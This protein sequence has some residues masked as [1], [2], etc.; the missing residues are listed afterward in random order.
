VQ[1]DAGSLLTAWGNF[2]V[3]TGTAAATLI[4]LMFVVITLVAGIRRRPSGGTDVFSTP[5]VVHFCGALFVAAT[6][7]AP[8]R[9]LIPVASL[10]GVAGLAG[11]AYVIIVLLRTRRLTFYK[12]VLEDWLWHMIFPFIA[13]TTIMVA[14]LLLPNNPVLALFCVG[15]V[16]V[17]LLFIGIHNAWDTVT[18][19]VIEY[20][21]PEK[22]SQGDAGLRRN[23][24]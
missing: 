7:S 2:Y 1:G 18:Y 19:L 15:A 4:G 9:A 11:I 22:E 17:L 14:A 3:I 13:Y 12:M 6:L 10:L 21:Q 20:A 23:D 24:V 5:T 16:T 8:W